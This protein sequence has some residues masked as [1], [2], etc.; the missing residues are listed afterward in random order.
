[1][2]TDLE[3]K[4]IKAAF[5]LATE[6]GWSNTT[7][8]QIAAKADVPMADVYLS[9]P[10]KSSILAAYSR[11]IDLKMLD[12]S[13]DVDEEDSARDRL[14]DVIMNRFDAMA[15]DRDALRVISQDVRYRPFEML[16]LRDSILH[17]LRWI[18]EAAGLDA[19]GARGAVRQ[20]GLALI[21]ADVFATWLKD[22][23]P[24]LAK[25][26]AQLDRRL[27]RVEDLIRR[28]Q[29]SRERF[30]RPDRE[31]DPENDIRTVH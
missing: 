8:S 19:G 29:S 2:E 3:A 23:D 20:R 22:D 7:L 4:I 28:L 11:Q 30:S 25:T 1:M 17:S 14:F 9:M 18:L 15:E 27:R 12:A 6:D 21:Y 5:K 24:G 26:M 13:D 31:S 16:A 10:T